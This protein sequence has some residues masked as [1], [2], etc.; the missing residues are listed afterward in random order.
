MSIRTLEFSFSFFSLCDEIACGDSGLLLVETDIS[1]SCF[2]YMILLTVK[3]SAFSVACRRASSN[4]AN[5][6]RRFW[7]SYGNFALG[8]IEQY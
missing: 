6:S 4:L 2:V 5:S 1:A 8:F 3:L 7:T